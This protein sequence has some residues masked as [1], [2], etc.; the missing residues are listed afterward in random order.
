MKP[1]KLEIKDE[2]NVKFH[3]LDAI[4]RRKLHSRFKYILP[5]ARHMP[6]YRLGRWDGSKPFFQMG[7]STFLH[8]LPQILPAL[9]DLGYDVTEIDDKRYRQPD[10]NF[11]QINEDTFSRITWPEGHTYEGEPIILRDYQVEIVQK[12]TE[13]LQCVQQISTGAGKSIVTA[14]LSHLVDPYG[15]TVVIV[16]NTNLV[17]QTAE[18]YR[19]V[20]LDTGVYYGKKKELDRRHTICTWQSLSKLLAQKNQAA[21]DFVVDIKAVIVDEA[22][23]SDSRIL[24]T[25]LTDH[26]SHVPIRWG[27]TGTIPKEEFRVAGIE[28]GIGPNVN[29]IRARELQ[30]AGVL[31]QCFV[32]V[33]QTQETTEYKDYHSEMKFLTSDG[34]RLDWLASKII[35]DIANDGN[36]LILVNKIETG[37]L[38]AERIT[39][40]VFLSGADGPDERK[41]HYDQVKDDSN[42]TI[43]ASYGIAST[44]INIVEIHNLVLLEPGRSFIRVIQSIGRGLRKSKSKDRVEIWDITSRC[45]FSRRHLNDRKRYYRE[46]EYEHKVF[47]VKY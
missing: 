44:G 43:I 20:G 45:R 27:L 39:D 37:K 1:C 23:G 22:H 18:D 4:T 15:H 2:V 34:D 21:A 24:L 13:N 16:P 14:V 47:K 41:R 12:F 7:G 35:N 31:A 25:I 6:S 32:N 8:L 9:N 42:K 10:F 17:N 40:S 36:T 26:L 38:L 3:N 33:L 29:T 11:P 5:Y 30:D 46:A 28:S 19:N